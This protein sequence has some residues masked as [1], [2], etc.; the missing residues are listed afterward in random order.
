MFSS[1]KNNS[2]TKAQL[3]TVNIDRDGVVSLNLRNDLVKA[4][5]KEQVFKLKK[6]NDIMNGMK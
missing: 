6:L 4:K 1:F 2:F 3:E 5:I